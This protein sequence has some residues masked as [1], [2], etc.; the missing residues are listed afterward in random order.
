MFN[1]IIDLTIF[2][3]IHNFLSDFMT[4]IFSNRRVHYFS[5]FERDLMLYI[6]VL[7]PKGRISIF[8]AILS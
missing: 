3:N 6:E 7:E 1:S 2:L 8:L 5:C 4:N